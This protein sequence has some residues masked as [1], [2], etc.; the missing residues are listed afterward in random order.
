MQELEAVIKS[1]RTL[2][3]TVIS[4]E[5]YLPSR[6]RLKGKCGKI[7]KSQV[8]S[9]HLENRNRNVGNLFGFKLIESANEIQLPRITESDRRPYV[10]HYSYVR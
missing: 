7:D 1:R 8:R 4:S 5:Q 6:G 2:Q 3:R 10:F 9:T